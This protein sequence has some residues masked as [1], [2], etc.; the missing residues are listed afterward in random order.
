[1]FA[2]TSVRGLNGFEGI[3]RGLVLC[4]VD[5]VGVALCVLV[6]F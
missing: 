4:H 2:T 3:S 5:H 6:G 1:M